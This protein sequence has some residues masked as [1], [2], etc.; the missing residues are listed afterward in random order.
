[1]LE[2]QGYPDITS[3]SMKT[4]PKIGCVALLNNRPVA[5]G[6]LRKIEGKM[7]MIDG[8]TS[9]AFLGSIIRH[10]GLSLVVDYLILEAKE[11]GIEEIIATTSDESVVKRA[12]SIGFQVIPHTIIGLK[13]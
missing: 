8:L 1:M 4:L 10:Q 6:F 2:S 5:A 9:N 12:E 3:V 13:L 11:L 7:G